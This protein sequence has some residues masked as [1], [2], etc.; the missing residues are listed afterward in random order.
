MKEKDI[1]DLLERYEQMLVT[2]K[3]IYFDA[4]EYE[5]LADYYDKLDDIETA[6]DVV[7]LGLKIHPDNEALMLRY[8]R[9]MIY[10]ANYMPALEYLNTHFSTYNFELYL[11]KIECYLQLGLYAEAHELTAE[12]LKDEDTE[13]EVILSELGFLYVEAEYFDEAILYFKKSLEYDPENKDVLNDLAYAYEANGDF[14]AAIEICERILDL[15]PYGFELWLMLGKLYSLNENYEKAVDAFDFALTLDDSNINVLKLKAHCLILSDRIPE[16]I[17]TLKQ[18]IILSP[19]DEISYLTLADC[20]LNLDDPKNMLTAIYD[21]ESKF[22]ETA[23]SIIKKAYAFFMKGKADAAED[24]IHQIL[25]HNPKSSYINLL[26]GNL[27]LKLGKISDAEVLYKKA[28]TLN[29]EGGEEILEKLVS[30]FVS[31][32]DFTNALVYQ[33]KI[34]DIENTTESKIKLALIYLEA[35]IKDN[36][37][38]YVQ[39]LSDDVLI[40]LL[41]VFYPNEDTFYENPADREYIIQRLYEVFESRQLYKNIKY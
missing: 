17:E 23:E 12:V 39:S 22:G 11:L 29:D 20:Y 14:D 24:L 4:D 1:S 10:E 7:D 26:A 40:S 2:G 38:E 27:Y 30:L 19:D 16:A 34:V 13:I 6:K 3:N 31:K 41:N 18:A 37:H 21:Y 25:K 32:N 33:K 35:G 5:E 15:D 28:L 8:A 9:F 36:Y